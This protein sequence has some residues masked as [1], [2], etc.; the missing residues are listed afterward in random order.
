[1]KIL[2][3][4]QYFGTPAGSWSTRIYEMTKRWVSEGID[5]E[6]ITAPYE[7]SDI[8]SSGFISS[9]IIDGIKLKVI[10][11][12]DSNRLPFYVRALRA[13]SFSLFSIYYALFSKYDVLLVSSGPITVGIPLILAKIIRRKKT[14]FEVRDLWPNGMVEL[15]LLKNPFAIKVAF[16]LEKLC[17]LNSN[18]VA[19]ASIGQRENIIS[20]FPN[21]KTIV[22]PHG[23]DNDLFG[24]KSEGSIP[25]NFLGKKL[26]THIGSLGLIHNI[27]F[28]INVAVEISNIG[29]NTITFIFIGEGAQRTMLEEMVASKGISNVEFLG[30]MPKRELPIWVQNSY[31]TLYATTNNPIQDTAAPNKIF[32]SFSAGVPIVQT[33]R[34]WVYDLVVEK[35]CGINVD[36]ASPLETAKAIIIYAENSDLRK[37]HAENSMILSLDQFNR[38]F[39]SKRYL[40]EIKNLR[41]G[42]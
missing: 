33:T 25:T 21:L 39:L 38:D 32:D 34:G 24:F 35:K 28:W 18:F 9:Q 22:I 1:M 12:P 19:T 6:V 30:L 23:C 27:S 29:N 10:N 31:A 8:K 3:I 41:L 37:L 7:K 16:Y 36:L 2:V 26:F 15:G 11:S 13:V 14:V 42:K 20:R 4:Y 17:Y 5:V 40:N